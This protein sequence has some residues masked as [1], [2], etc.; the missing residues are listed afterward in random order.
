V[1]ADWPD[2]RIAADVATLLADPAIDLVVVSSPDHLHAKHAIAALH[3]GKHVV[4][5]KP[6]AN[7]LEEALAVA[8]EAERHGLLLT[9]FH[10]RRWDAD[11]LTLRRQIDEGKLGTIV[12][13]ESRFD[14]WRPEPAAVWKESRIAGSWLDL[15]PHLV[16]QA[17]VLFGRPQSISLDLA[18]LREGAPAP[19]YF[20]AV[21]AYDGLRVILHGSKLVADHGLRFAVHGTKGSWI[22]HGTDIQE[23]AVLSGLHPL[24]RDWGADPLEGMFT[25]GGQSTGNRVANEAGDYRRFW[26]A[27]VAALRG[28]GPNPVNP[29]E[30]LAVMEVLAAGLK[31][32][33]H[34]LAEL[35]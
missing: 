4:I 1:H 16:D 35:L 13:F 3:A 11:F 25:S 14:R 32:S 19:D 30:A 23:A 34:G 26:S 24:G 15:G 12:Q 8:A 18:T 21:L 22:K 17:L 33:A 6:F 20:H 2:V 5:D 9:V 27:L 29:Q 10:N 28:E 7:S 31:S